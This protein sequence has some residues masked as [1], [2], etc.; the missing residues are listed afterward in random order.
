MSSP[1]VVSI[2]TLQALIAETEAGFNPFA[3]INKNQQVDKATSSSSS[4]SSSPVPFVGS[5]P[6]SRADGFAALMIAKKAG[7]AR[8]AAE[9]AATIQQTTRAGKII[10][11]TREETNDNDHAAA[12]HTSVHV[13]A[14]IRTP[15]PLPVGSNTPS[16]TPPHLLSSTALV[17]HRLIDRE[18]SPVPFSS[19]SPVTPTSSLL[20]PS[21]DSVLEEAEAIL[22]GF[23]SGSNVSS[24]RSPTDLTHVQRKRKD[25]QTKAEVTS[26]LAQLSNPN[27]RK[28]KSRNIQT[29]V[30]ST[31]SPTLQQ[32]RGGGEFTSDYHPPIPIDTPSPLGSPSPSLRSNIHIHIQQPLPSPATPSFN[33]GHMSFLEAGEVSVVG[34]VDDDDDDDDGDEGYEEG[35]DAVMVLWDENDPMYQPD[36]SSSSTPTIH[37][38]TPIDRTVATPLA[39][40]ED[41]DD[42]DSSLNEP[43]RSTHDSHR[44]TPTNTRPITYTQP[45]STITH[46]SMLSHQTDALPPRPPPSMTTLINSPSDANVLSHSHRSSPSNSTRSTP[47][48]SPRPLDGIASGNTV[49][50][51]G[52]T[53]I[54]FPVALPPRAHSPMSTSNTNLRS[55]SPASSI[56]GSGAVP[57]V[58]P[59]SQ[60]RPGRSGSPSPLVGV[61]AGGGVG[62]GPILSSKA[63]ALIHGKTLRQQRP[64]DLL[65]MLRTNIGYRFMLIQCYREYSEENVLAFKLIDSY[66]K[67]PSFQTLQNFVQKYVRPGSDLMINLSSATRKQ[68]LEFVRAYQ[69]RE[70]AKKAAHTNPPSSSASSEPPLMDLADVLQSAHREILALLERDSFQRFR[71]SL[72]YV[73][74]VSGAQPPTILKRGGEVDEAEDTA[75]IATVKNQFSN[76]TKAQLSNK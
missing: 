27:I 41:D 47:P 73:A 52:A 2:A 33:P 55:P 53:S 44:A 54:P 20:S 34:F 38:S 5:T 37:R 10:K 46:T 19:S 22:A 17:N 28:S 50:G 62:G 69:E 56:T 39:L 32:A 72:L 59:S 66:R 61:G 71:S 70:A 21:Q 30:T 64:L 16:P 7:E 40:L 76:A 58:T 35:A 63:Y 75:L 1:P 29:P 8:K 26:M 49:I 6:A 51:V 15:A 67:H 48:I 23:L 9:A 3:K 13:H 43:T 4:S 24:R 57:S 74:Y 31:P 65:G 68:I 14:P 12:A 18:P 36:P 42:T 45:S 60:L 11:T 25:I